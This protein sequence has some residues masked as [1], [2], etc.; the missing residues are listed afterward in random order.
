MPSL[1][2]FQKHFKC[3]TKRN[4][5]AV[6]QLFQ[7]SSSL[8]S[9]FFNFCALLLQD[10]VCL[11]TPTSPFFWSYSNIYSTVPSL[12]L[13]SDNSLVFSLHNFW[14]TELIFSEWTASSSIC[15]LLL[16]IHVPTR[17]H[18]YLLFNKFP[19]SNILIMQLKHLQCVWTIDQIYTCHYVSAVLVKLAL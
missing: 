19:G 1:L 7:S 9:R 16:D 14:M 11:S 6:V 18:F 10:L 12:A 2:F 5:S 13:L 8:A 17:S 3:L 15:T 4:A